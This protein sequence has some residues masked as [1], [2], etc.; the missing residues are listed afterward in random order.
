MEIIFSAMKT[1]VLGFF[2]LIVVVV[3]LALIFGKR[4]RKQWEYEATFR[5]GGG[6]EFAEF[7]V[8]KSRIEKVEADYAVKPKLWMRHPSL[9]AGQTVRVF[10]NDVLVLEGRVETAG[11]IRLGRDHVV[12]RPESF[13]AGQACRVELASG[14]QFTAPLKPD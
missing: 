9:A 14:E 7:E 5:D 8:E 11:R 6:R 13:A 4:I 3:V 10:V 12:N 1:L 2:G